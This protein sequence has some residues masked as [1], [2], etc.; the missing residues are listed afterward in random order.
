MVRGFDGLKTRL[1]ALTGIIQRFIDFVV[2]RALAGME[3][4]GIEIQYIMP[5]G[6]TCRGDLVESEERLMALL[7]ADDLVIICESEEGLKECIRSMEWQTQEWGL[8]I[9]VKKT[10]CMVTDSP[11]KKQT[12]LEEINIRGEGIEWV[13][14]FQYL[15]SILNEDAKCTADIDRRLSLGII[16]FS[17]L[18][19]TVWNQPF[20]SVKTKVMI[21]R[22][23]VISTVLYGS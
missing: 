7:Y 3:K 2:R 9:S 11:E 14:S 19:K 13:N 15:G 8:T 4:Y 6:R 10:K 22:A 23:V 20:I 17:Q 18:Q 21:Y 12:K 16:K 5:D 1:P